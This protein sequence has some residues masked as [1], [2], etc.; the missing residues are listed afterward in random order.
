MSSNYASAYEISDDGLIIEGGLH[1]LSGVASPVGVINPSNATLYMRTNG[2]F[3]YHSGTGGNGAWILTELSNLPSLSQVP[4]FAA[5]GTITSVTF[6]IGA[7]QTTP[8][9][10]ADVTY[11]YDVNLNPATEVANVYSFADG[12]TILS[13]VTKTFTFTSGVLTNITQVTT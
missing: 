7:T 1:F 11:T 8:Y 6:Y 10:I 13:T 5:N 3:W 4:V 2:D 9:R 12:T